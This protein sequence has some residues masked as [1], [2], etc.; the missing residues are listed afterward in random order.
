MTLIQLSLA[1]GA[2]V[3]WIQNVRR[4]L[5]RPARNDAREAHWLGLVHELHVALGCPL[6]NAA[7][8]ADLVLAA[9]AEQRTL[10]VPL[11]EGIAVL[12]L[13]LWR[14]QSVHLA[15]L[16]RALTLPPVERR[17]RPPARRRRS[18]TSRAVEYGVDVERLRTGLQRT[19]SE[20]LVR[21]DENTAFLAAGRASLARRPAG[22]RTE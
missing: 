14:E 5:A 22:E 21:L 9:P 11:G 7:R 1:A 17:G 3:K 10:E 6:A 8:L 20:R 12:T 4:L 15:R 18:T 13:D 16:S 2:D 19:V